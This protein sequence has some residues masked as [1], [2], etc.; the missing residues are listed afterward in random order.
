MRVINEGL[1]QS[2]AKHKRELAHARGISFDSFLSA[3]ECNHRQGS[4]P[5][6][7]PLHAGESTRCRTTENHREV[8]TAIIYDCRV[9]ARHN[10]SRTLH[11][12][13]SF[14]LMLSGAARAA[15][16]AILPGE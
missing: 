4:L 2:C 16:R 1:E 5:K 15:A 8:Q 6:K 9:Q 3:N 7:T 13:D 11:T 10:A 14:V 12:E